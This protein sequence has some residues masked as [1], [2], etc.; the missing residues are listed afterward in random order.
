MTEPEDSNLFSKQPIQTVFSNFA[1]LKNLSEFY[2][3]LEP[4]IRMR[5]CKPYTEVSNS[6]YKFPIATLHDNK[7]TTLQSIV[8]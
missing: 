4:Q 1:S 5:I 6:A 8:L 7:I 3:C 2:F